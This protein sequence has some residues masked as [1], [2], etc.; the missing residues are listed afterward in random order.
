MCVCVGE[1]FRQQERRASSTSPL[2]LRSDQRRVC[3]FAGTQTASPYTY[4]REGRER[5]RERDTDIE[6]VKEVWL[7]LQRSDSIILS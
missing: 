7:E 1:C 5:E 2:G 4:C 6:R 3:Q